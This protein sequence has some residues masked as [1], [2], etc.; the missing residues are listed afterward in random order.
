[1]KTGYAAAALAAAL[2]GLA[3][4][5]TPGT[6]TEVA[7]ATVSHSAAPA[8]APRSAEPRSAVPTPAVTK[9]VIKYRSVTATPTAAPAPAAPAPAAPA[10]TAAPAADPNVTEPW[11]VVSAYYGDIESGDYAGAWALLNSGMT[12]GQT[13][14]QFVDGFAC[15]G[16]QLLS[17]NWSS[18]DEVNFDLAATDSCTGAVQDFS[19]TDTV[20]GGLIVAADVSQTG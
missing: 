13:Y 2:L 16:S 11:A 15:T 5:A 10:T 9:T 4:C 18:G 1:M 6:V 20:Q 17:E 12:T 8:S 3:A 7:P 14:Q 19:G